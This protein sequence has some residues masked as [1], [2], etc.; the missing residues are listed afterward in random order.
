MC[1]ECYL[2]GEYCENHFSIELKSFSL[3]MAPCF[4]E[5]VAGLWQGKNMQEDFREQV[6]DW[7]EFQELTVSQRE[8]LLASPDFPR[9]L[10]TQFTIMIRTTS[11]V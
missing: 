9:R 6:E 4:M 7:E 8:R 3:P 2:D 11:K 1:Y 5:N 10:L